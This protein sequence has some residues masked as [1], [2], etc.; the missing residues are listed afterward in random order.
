LGLIRFQ[1]RATSVVQV[2]HSLPIWNGHQF[3][4]IVHREFRAHDDFGVAEPN[5]VARANT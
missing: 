5:P 4:T 1:F 2:R 3:I